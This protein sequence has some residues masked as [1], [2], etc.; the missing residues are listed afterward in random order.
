MSEPVKKL[1]FRE[2]MK[3]FPAWQIFVISIIRF[4]E[5]VAFTSLFPYVYFMIRD[6]GI[7]K[8][9]ADIA[10][11]SGYLSASF[12][13]FQF[14]CCVQWGRASDRVGRKK[15]LLLGLLGTASS[16]VLFGF[17]ANFYIAMLARSSMGVLNGNIAVLRTAIGEIATERRHQAMAFSTLPLLWNIGAVVGPMI[18]GSKYLTRPKNSVS[19]DAIFT[20]DD[21]S[22][23]KFITKF[24]YALSNIVVALFLLFSFSVGIL[25]LEE[26]H[27]RFKN[28]RD[29]GL[30]IGDSIR[31]FFGF[32]IPPRPWQKASI[33]SSSKKS[34]V[35]KPK[36]PSPEA[37][38]E[39]LAIDSD[40]E[41]TPF[42]Q[43]QQLYAST[44][45]DNEEGVGSD[46]DSIESINGIM[47][48]RMSAAL[49]RRYSSNQLGPVISSNFE[50]ESIITTNIEQGFNKE[51]FTAPVVQT[52]IANF[53]TSFHNIVYSEFLP[54]LLAGD[55]LVDEI[56][57]PFTLKGGFGFESSTI[58]MLLSTTGLIGGL[59]ILFIFPIIDRNFK[60]INAYRASA[61][62]FP[63]SYAVLPYLVFTLHEY[64]PNFPKGLTKKLLYVLCCCNSFSGSVGFPNILI[65]IHRSSPAKHRAFINGSA[66]SLSSLARFIGP[67]LFGY[68]MSTTDKYSIGE[69]AWFSLSF[70]SICCV[71]Q[72][73]FMKDYEEDL[74]DD[75][76]DA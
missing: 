32:D 10:T 50:T 7:A 35:R 57:F 21:S 15:I 13:F 62:I 17:S 42:N 54:V 73:F 74:K 14:L 30:E 69:V 24:P 53:L 70:L 52:I 25:F 27:P 3:G 6:F 51:I 45:Q 23:E 2:Q 22:Y 76:N 63:F 12:A 64:N 11:Y 5:P 19:S 56:K 60:T 31:R 49:V 16:M 68:I 20:G 48:R 61:L 18:G 26:S 37:Q 66:L 36:T 4:A 39:D 1:T 59:G 29:R 43:P 58:G 33:K 9:K 71:I 65:L 55:L 28:K 75:E 8:N 67:I 47:S 44:N 40:D 46:T 38:P 72:A 41:I 34:V